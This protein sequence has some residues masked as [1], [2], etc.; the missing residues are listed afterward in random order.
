MDSKKC[1]VIAVTNQK[2]GVGKTTTSMN[3]AHALILKG[4]RVAVIDLDPH[5]YLT[6]GLGI[7]FRDLGVCVADLIR[8][9]K[10]ETLVALKK[11]SSGLDLIGSHPGLA[12]VAREMVSLTNSELR[13]KQRVDA[14]RCKY[15]III[16]DSC[17]GFGPL[18][19]S[20]LNAADFLVIPVDTGFYGFLGFKQLEGEIEEIKLG[21][22]PSLSVLG[23]VLTM[24]DRTLVSRETMDALVGMYRADVF[25]TQIRRCV[26]LRESPALGQ[27]VFQYAPKSIGAQDYMELC[28]EV[29]IRITGQDLAGHSTLRLVSGLNEGVCHD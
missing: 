14:L 24:S 17:P 2:G 11:T 26:G 28:E 13:L 5:G 8:D 18:L 29:I 7:Q 19:N 3:L 6:Q 1:H 4:Y 25:T 16:I 23:F 10:A 20:A 9:R 27:T 21:T 22:N 12:A 15:D